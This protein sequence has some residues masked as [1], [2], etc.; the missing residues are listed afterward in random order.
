M[1]AEL[2]KTKPELKDRIP[3]A[4]GYATF[5][6][7]DKNLFLLAS[8]RGY[9]VL[10]DNKTGKDTFMFNEVM[11]LT[12]PEAEKFWRV[13]SKYEKEPAA[14]G[15]RKLALIREFATL[16]FGGTFDN[17]K[18]DD[19]AGRWLKNTQE[20]LDL[21]KKY[22]QQISEAVSP[23][24]AAQ[25]LQVEH[26]MALLIDLNI[27]AR[28]ILVVVLFFSHL[29]AALPQPVLAAVVLV[30]V[31]GLFKVSALKE[32]WRGDRPEFVVAMAAIVGVLGQGLLRGVM[33][34]AIISLV[35]LIRRASRPHVAFL[36]RIPG[37]RRFSDRERHPGNELIPG[38]LIFR[39]ESGLLYFNMDH[40][41]DIILDRVHAEPTPPKLVV[42]D[43]SAAPRVDM[44]SAHMLGS[45][46][47]EL[48]ASGIQ[49][50][51]VEARSSVRE[52]LR[53]Q[54]VDAKLGG[55]DRFTT[56]CDAVKAFQ[57]QATT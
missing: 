24:R 36:G 8:G 45:L 31:A 9:G 51:A 10:K 21:W 17:Q 2:Y 26:Q 7:T 12:G 25:F 47:A 53:G 42:L 32:L 6:Q 38:V 39:P 46:A 19:L 28:I 13:Y 18:A 40:V 55:I 20:R 34:G 15:D 14:V 29:L 49:L 52:R 50:Q 22:H 35:L 44:H 57:K 43:L 1:L 23:I 5:K 11:K 16:H 4:A 48:T 37:T 27:A 41:R 33:I 30:A 3:K 54:G 56:I